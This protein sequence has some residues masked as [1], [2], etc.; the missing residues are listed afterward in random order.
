[1]SR[2]GVLL[3]GG[4]GFIGNALAKRLRLEGVPT[5]VVGRDNGDAMGDLLPRCGTVVHLASGTTPGSSARYPMLEE[6]NL[7]LTLHLLEWIQTRSPTHLIF[8]S[9]GGT[10]YG[11][12]ATFPVTEDS[13]LTPLSYHGAGKVAQEV[14]CK[15]LT[16]LGHAVTV[17]R[18]SNAYGPGQTLRHGFGLIRTMLQHAQAGSRLEIWGDGE[19]VR[20]YIY[21]DDVVEATLRLIGLPEDCGTYNLGSGVG[22]SINQVKAVVEQVCGCALDT[23]YRAARGMDVRSVVLDNAHLREQAGWVPEV[24]LVNGIKQTWAWLTCGH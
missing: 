1:M 9:S 4:G 19:N 2:D 16:T 3:L 21:I 6:D 20:D 22:H 13:P 5:H 17:L 18:P 7:A 8:F 12:P 11:N 15:T 14:L 10:V 24:G 23:T